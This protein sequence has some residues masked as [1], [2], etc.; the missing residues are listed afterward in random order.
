MIL[1]DTYITFSY[2]VRV[3][4]AMIL[5]SSHRP[6]QFPCDKLLVKMRRKSRKFEKSLKLHIRVYRQVL[7]FFG[8]DSR[9][10]FMIFVNIEASTHLDSEYKTKLPLLP[11]QVISLMTF[12]SN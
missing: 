12:D 2:S 3:T 11:L 6:L 1:F 9:F 10:M 5:L 7:P 4:Y 8:P